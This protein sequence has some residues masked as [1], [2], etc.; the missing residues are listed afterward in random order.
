M[1]VNNIVGTD[2]ATTLVVAVNQP[3]LSYNFKYSI[4]AFLMLATWL[5]IFFAALFIL[6]TGALQFSHM[7]HLLN[8][9]SVGRII[10]GDSAL[11]AISGPGAPAE[12][13]SMG[14]AHLETAHWTET[15]GS[16]RVAFDGLCSQTLKGI[17]R[18]KMGPSN[19][20]ATEGVGPGR[21]GDVLASSLLQDGVEAHPRRSLRKVLVDFEKMHRS[22]TTPS[23]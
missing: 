4:P 14:T 23:S 13:G 19:D 10:V 1:V 20:S 18:E 5:P 17:S 22:G 3:S 8:Q 7:R 6:L 12:T 16:T 2:T 11:T 15:T 9:T 21:E